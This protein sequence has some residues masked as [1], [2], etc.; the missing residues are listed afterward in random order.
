MQKLKEHRSQLQQPRR[1]HPGGHVNRK[2]HQLDLGLPRQQP[3]HRRNSF[4]NR[5]PKQLGH[6]PDG[7]QLPQRSNP[8]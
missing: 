4:R 7:Q 2:L 1:T 3:S 5:E 6:P 8:T